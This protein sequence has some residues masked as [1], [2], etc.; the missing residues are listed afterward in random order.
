MKYLVTWHF[1]GDL[2][3]H[4]QCCYFDFENT[5]MSLYDELNQCKENYDDVRILKIADQS[6]KIIKVRVI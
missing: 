1:K 6:R 5:A 3:R 4:C 2:T